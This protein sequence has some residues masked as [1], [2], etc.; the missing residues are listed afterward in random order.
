MTRYAITTQAKVPKDLESFDL[1]G[2]AF[3]AGASEPDR[4]VFRRKLV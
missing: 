1:E 4:K 3:A 2:Y